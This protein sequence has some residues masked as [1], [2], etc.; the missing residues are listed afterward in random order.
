MKIYH[1]KTQQDYDALMSELEVKGYKW[2]S[3]R[4]PTEKNYWEQNKESSCVI[5]LSK[6]IGF[7]NIEQS[8]KQHPNIPVVEYKAKEKT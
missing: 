6:Y 4:E 5:I 2:L 8:K 1:V 3:G 7:M